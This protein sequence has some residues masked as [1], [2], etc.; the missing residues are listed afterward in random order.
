MLSSRDT[1]LL[2]DS[3]LRKVGITNVVMRAGAIEVATTE[4]GFVPREEMSYKY[5]PSSRLRMLF[6]ALKKIDDDSLEK[7]KQNDTVFFDVVYGGMHGN[8]AVGDGFKYRGRGFNQITFRDIYHDIGIK[9]GIDLVTTPERLNEPQV[10]ASAL[11][12]YFKTGFMSIDQNH[13]VLSRF[14]VVSTNDIYKLE[15]AAECC[16]QINAGWKTSL[17][18]ARLSEELAQEKSNIHDIFNIINPTV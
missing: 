9:I 10:A 11:A 2:I 8:V 14:G 17:K 18:N 13:L 12:A 5:T 4:G 16:L 1:V 15:D 7:I 3:E 6:A